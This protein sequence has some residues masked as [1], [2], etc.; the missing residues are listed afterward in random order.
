[1]ASKTVNNR[2]AARTVPTVELRWYT[3]TEC[4]YGTLSYRG[5]SCEQ[6][7]ST[8][9]IIHDQIV[10]AHANNFHPHKKSFMTRLFNRN[11]Q[12][13]HSTR[14]VISPTRFPPARMS[15]VRLLPRCALGHDCGHDQ[16]SGAPCAFLVFFAA[17]GLRAGS[18][19]NGLPP[20][21]YLTGGSAYGIGRYAMRP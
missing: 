11:L 14:Y 4:C 19:L 8:Q 10:A 7:S 2:D 18:S 15:S 17:L 1:M 6:L 5:S 21:P 16:V 3:C 9:E 12:K 13:R 20:S